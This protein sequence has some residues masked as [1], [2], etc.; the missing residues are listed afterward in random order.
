M[1]HS[2]VGVVEFGVMVLFR[3]S[4]GTMVLVTANVALTSD[5]VA[6]PSEIVDPGK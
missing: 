4:N 3:R 1:N 5:K 2:T 6:K